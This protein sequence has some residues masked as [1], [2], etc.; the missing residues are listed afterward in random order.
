[1]K[2]VVGNTNVRKWTQ[3]LIPL[4][5]THTNT[6]PGTL[7]PHAR[8]L[9]FSFYL[10][11]TL[12]ITYSVS[13]PSSRRIHSDCTSRNSW[14]CIYLFFFTWELIKRHIFAWQK[15]STPHL[16]ASDN[17]IRLP[18]TSVPVWGANWRP[19]MSFGSLLSVWRQNKA[20]SV[21]LKSAPG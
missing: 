12:S 5:E 4:V 16:Y 20:R 14:H 2:I 9:S 13:S 7:L 3:T 15:L 19:S 6:L 21:S 8:T 18:F 1:M 10:S 11:Y 17:P